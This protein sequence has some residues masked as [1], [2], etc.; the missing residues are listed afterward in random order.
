[1]PYRITLLA[2]TVEAIS[3]VKWLLSTAAGKKSPLNSPGH[4]YRPLRFPYR[5]DYWKGKRLFHTPP[6]ARSALPERRCYH[7][8]RDSL[9]RPD[10]PTRL[11]RL[12]SQ[13]RIPNDSSPC[14][15]GSPDQRPAIDQITAN[16]GAREIEVGLTVSKRPESQRRMRGVVII[17]IG[18]V[19]GFQKKLS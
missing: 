11:G 2:G 13:P 7:E 18:I 12:R 6:A 8:R 9:R 4:Y 3:Y 1:M 5:P 15:R 10:A 19:S 14:H 17:I 16:L